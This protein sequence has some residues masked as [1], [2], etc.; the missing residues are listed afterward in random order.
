MTADQEPRYY[1]TQA[2]ALLDRAPNTLR[3]WESGKKIPRHLY[4][5]RDERNHRY[6]TPSLI[7]QIKEWIEQNDFYPGRSISYHP[8]QERR[9]EHIRRIRKSRQRNSN[10]DEDPDLGKKLDD[11]YDL[12]IE[13]IEKHDRSLDEIVEM[14][15]AVAKQRGIPLREAVETARDAFYAAEAAGQ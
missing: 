7:A 5:F 2:A 11:L 10:K 3:D 15:P 12:V 1:I 13:A 9:T 8:D 6:W 4:A 14:M